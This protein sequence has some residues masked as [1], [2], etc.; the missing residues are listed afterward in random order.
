M[1]SFTVLLR[2]IEDVAVAKN[3]ARAR[4][5]NLAVI[6]AL[7]MVPIALVATSAVELALISK[8]RSNLQSAVDAGALAGAIELS[9]ASRGNDGISATAKAASSQALGVEADDAS[10]DVLID[11]S[12]AIVRVN[13]HIDRK[14]AMGI[15]NIGD[16]DLYA[17]ATAESLQTIPLCI[18]Q[19]T[20][21]SAT[22]RKPSGFKVN[23]TA[24][25]NAKGCLVHA[26]ESIVVGP[27]GRIE[28]TRVQAVGTAS[29][30]IMPMGNVGALP[31]K[32]PFK[33][34]NLNPPRSCGSNPIPQIVERGV[35]L[36]LEPGLHCQ[37]FKVRG[38]A[39]LKLSP[40]EHYFF[41]DLDMRGESSLVGE[42]VVL[43][44]GGTERF[45]FGE[46]SHV[47]LSARRTGRFAGFLMATH[48]DNTRDFQ[49]SSK[50]VKELLGTIY[51]PNAEL[52][53][54]A[55]GSVAEESAW[56]VIVARAITLKN[57]PKLVINTSYL[58]SGVPVPE[59]V[60][61][62]TG[63]PRLTK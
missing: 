57:N 53:I 20:R 58:S 60:G 33:G 31:I 3:F 12:K 39:T 25:I 36:V 13:G 62:N 1:T 7:A 8:E 6:A 41:G 44:F 37:A 43:I 51:V 61:P 52:V 10:F 46:R 48:Q 14:A 55:A 56:S 2:L 22:R 11:R 21:R 38:T 15:G 24:T 42:D 40:G 47:R 19:T 30:T 59:G 5:G 27:S 50:N 49:I 35:T 17:S 4:R 32:D 54:S 16:A 9:R 34:M 28:A 18:L 63:A 29:G 23:D 45:D 26:N